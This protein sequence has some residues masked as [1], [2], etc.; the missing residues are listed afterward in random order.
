MKKFLIGIFYES[1]FIRRC[2]MWANEHRILFFFLMA[3]MF[4]IAGYDG[5]F[6]GIIVSSMVSLL[7]AHYFLKLNDID[8]KKMSLPGPGVV[9][10]TSQEEAKF[11][12]A[13]SFVCMVFF[14]IFCLILIVLGF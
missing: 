5:G 12:R 13:Y 4:S 6:G 7:P 2:V 8:I 11:L 10:I 9:T 1:E 3:S 14:S